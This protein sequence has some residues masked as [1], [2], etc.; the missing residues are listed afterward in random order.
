MLLSSLCPYL[1]ACTSW[2][3]HTCALC[4]CALSHQLC[5]W[6]SSPCSL[7]HV[8]RPTPGLFLSH[9]KWKV[10]YYSVLD[11]DLRQG[12]AVIYWAATGCHSWIFCI[13]HSKHRNNNSACSPNK[14]CFCRLCL[15]H[16]APV[17]AGAGKSRASPCIP[18]FQEAAYNSFLHFKKRLNSWKYPKSVP[19]LASAFMVS[20]HSSQLQ[21]MLQFLLMLCYHISQ[22]WWTLQVITSH[23]LLDQPA[24][25][26]DNAMHSSLK[27]VE[28]AALTTEASSTCRVLV[29]SCHLTGTVWEE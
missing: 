16:V 11:C 3:V 23:I 27:S 5:V 2:H 8:C 6:P 19:S 20:L 12:L 15:M 1:S 22:C 7:L 26:Q 14:C 10:H 28:D 21:R 24:I 18:L 25:P 29:F 9:L 4:T 17:C 13:S